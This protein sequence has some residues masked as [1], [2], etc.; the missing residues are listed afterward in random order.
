MRF[1]PTIALFS[2]GLAFGLLLPLRATATDRCDVTVRVV[3]FSFSAAA[4]PIQFNRLENFRNELQQSGRLFFEDQQISLG[5]GQVSFIVSNEWDLF[6]LPMKLD[7][8]DVF[9]GFGNNSS[10]DIAQRVRPEKYVIADI[11]Y[12]PLVTQNHY[13]RTLF[14]ISK[15]PQEFLE[16]MF[17]IKLPED[18]PLNSLAEVERELRKHRPG[19]PEKILQTQ[20]QIRNAP[21]LS[22]RDEM[23]ALAFFNDVKVGKNFPVDTGRLKDFTTIHKAFINRYFPSNLENYDPSGKIVQD[24]EYSFLN[25][26]EA[27]DRTKSLVTN[28]QFARTNYR[29]PDFWKQVGKEHQS[30]SGDKSFTVYLSNILDAVSRSPE[31]AQTRLQE[32]SVLLK[33]Q[34]ETDDIRIIITKGLGNSHTFEVHDLRQSPP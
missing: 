3:Y 6:K 11:G 22:N 15:T 8:T 25:S 33:D 14:S 13:F 7:H 29:S 31:E 26:Q 5:A 21:E 4:P 30:S 28:A 34:L 12:E 16:H 23:N 24:P 32:I 1:R 10:W 19:D 27:F 2:L 9:I 20:R 18:Q 17:Q